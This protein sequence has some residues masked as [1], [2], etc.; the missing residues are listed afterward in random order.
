INQTNLAAWSA[1]QSGEAVLSNVVTLNAK[2]NEATRYVP[3]IIEPNSPSYPQLLTIYEGIQ[4][5]RDLYPDNTF[6]RL[7]D[8]L[9]VPKLT[10]ASIDPKDPASLFLDRCRTE[11]PYPAYGINDEALAHIPQLILS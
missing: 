11:A 4:R 9:S 5:V 1:Q 7:G 10:E 6:R 2:G 8:L 3:V